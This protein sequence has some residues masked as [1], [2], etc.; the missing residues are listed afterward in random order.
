MLARIAPAE[1]PPATAVKGHFTAGLRF[2]RASA[3][4]RALVDSAAT[5][6]Y[7]TYIFHTLVVLYAVRILGLN[8][9]TLGLVVGAGAVGGLLGAAVTGRFVR[10]IGI[11][12][13]IVLG[14]VGFPV[15]LVLVPLAGGP[16]ELVLA[17]FFAAEFLSGFGVMLLDIGCGSLQAAVIPDVLR[18]RVSGAFRT[19]NYGMRPLGALTGGLLGSTIGLRPT[20][21]IATVGGVLSV[22]WLL[23][24]PV[25]R[26]RELPVKTG[27]GAAADGDGSG[28]ATAEN[29]GT[30]GGAS[31]GAGTGA[32]PGGAGTPSGV[33]AGTE[34]GG[35]GA[36]AVSAGGG[37]AA[38]PPDGEISGARGAA[39]P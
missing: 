31:P 2:I 30:P 27:S 20:L 39:R 5:V 12:P 28:A 35:S 18:S 23:P 13:T 17:A 3:V 34:P 29:A 9:G 36:A 11:G 22:L 4:M 10:R 16:R 8:A 15:P 33:G 1:P 38:V 19:V 25:P 21:W 37:A 26:M 6:N 24:S 32:P 7:F 14:I